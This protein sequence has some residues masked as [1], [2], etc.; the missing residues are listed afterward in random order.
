MY[1]RLGDSFMVVG[2][3]LDHRGVGRK[4]DWGKKRLMKA[5]SKFIPFVDSSFVESSTM[6]LASL[7]SDM[8]NIIRADEFILTKF[9]RLADK[10]S[11]RPS[12]SLPSN[13]QPNLKGSSSKPYQPPQARNEHVNAVFTW[14]GKSYD[15][16]DNPNDKQNDSKTPINFNSD[17]EPTPQPKPKTPK[18][19]KETPISKP[20][21][22]KIPYP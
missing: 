20:Y 5:V 13:T 12:G 10:Q 6:F 3:S 14:S 7:M 9:D 16:P 17:D 21:K 15:L 8:E 19:V 4:G 18:P 1:Q 2:E 11:G 22:P